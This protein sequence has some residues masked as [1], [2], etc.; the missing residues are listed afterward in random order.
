MLNATKTELIYF[1]SKQTKIPQS[2]I[3]LN[4]V[5]LFE[6]EEVKYVG[7][8]LDQ[9]LT[10]KPHINILNARLKRA[11]NLIAISRHYLSESL[12]IQVYYG[13]F[14]LHITYGCQL[15][16]QNENSISKTITLQNK[17]IGL[18]TFSQN[19]SSSSYKK[20]KLLKLTDIIKM[21][22]MLF[23]HANL[24]NNTPKTFTNFFR[25]KNTT[26]RHNTINSINSTYSMPNGSLTI[27]AYN[28]SFGDNSLKYV[29]SI[30]WNVL[31][32]KLSSKFPK[33]YTS[34]P[35]WLKSLTAASLKTTLKNFFL[36]QY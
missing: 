33:E 31:F 13:Q 28:S 25:F 11:N 34:N 2:K 17:A 15:W 26:H 22:N 19:Y 21:N 14:Y 8:I 35:F 23:T 32:R 6:K 27:P 12:L 10:F 7:L 16:G 5:K 36:E 3:K 18:L 24:N 4:G 9:H 20:L 30:L 1:R 29:C